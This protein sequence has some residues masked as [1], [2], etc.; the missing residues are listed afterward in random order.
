MVVRFLWLPEI[1]LNIN[2]SD[3]MT[4][5]K[6]LPINRDY[7]K[8]VSSK[9]ETGDIIEACFFIT[10]YIEG[11]LKDW[12]LIIGK[13]KPK[14]ILDIK[15]KEIESMKLDHVVQMHLF[16][17]NIDKKLFDSIN[18]IKNLRHSF[19][20]CILKIDW[21]N[22]SEIIKYKKIIIDAVDT[23]DIIYDKYC[24]QLNK[25]SNTIIDSNEEM[26]NND[27]YVTSTGDLVLK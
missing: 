16:L 24:I 25:T 5:H 12:L 18:K 26:L 21:N 9:L 4:K 2:Q 14:G 6:S 23:C 13:Q 17:D 7:N 27:Y 1:H 20:H 11:Y 8:I 15:L 3:L 19:A 10:Q 22:Q